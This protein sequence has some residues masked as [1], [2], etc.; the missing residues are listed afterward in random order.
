MSIEV[1]IGGDRLGSGKKM[2]QWMHDYERAN[3]DLSYVWRSSMSA[4]PLV[5][6]MSMIQTPGDT[7]DINLRA[8]VKT[9]PTIG[10]LFGSYKLQ[11]DVFECPIRL[12]NGLLHNNELNI[13]M[14][15]KDVMLPRMFVNCNAIKYANDDDIPVDLQQI[16]QSSLLAYLGIRGIGKGAEQGQEFVQTM[17]NA[18]SVIA[19][20][21]I[22][23]NFYAN[24]Q[25][26]EGAIIDISKRLTIQISQVDW[27]SST[28]P[29]GWV[30]IGKQSF[31]T[32]DLIVVTGSNL[33][34]NGG[35]DNIY[36]T[37]SNKSESQTIQL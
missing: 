32:G 27:M 6:F 11:L 18:T 4:G 26:E 19:Y 37:I 17:M 13:G 35:A 24:K 3:H 30:N 8:D 5:P 15:M 20:Y 25:E 16:N 31:G 29:N 34:K 36:F 2:K 7:F 28:S 22:Y 23:K 21:D 9:L 10:P 33:D 14:T 12:Y 1:T